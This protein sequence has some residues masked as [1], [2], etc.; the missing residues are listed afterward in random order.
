MILIY[1]YDSYVKD[2]LREEEQELNYVEESD[3]SSNC[4]MSQSIILDNKITKKLLQDK[5]EENQDENYI[6]K[7]VDNSI[8]F[9]EEIN[10]KN[11]EPISSLLLIKKDVL[12]LI[13]LLLF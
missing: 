5:D 2:E 9:N 3:C 13:F 12:L 6:R 7:F 1:P 10:Y 4:Q 8:I 11:Y